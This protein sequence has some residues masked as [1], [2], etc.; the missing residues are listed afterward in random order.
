[1]PGSGVKQSFWPSNLKAYTARRLSPGTYGSRWLDSKTPEF[2]ISLPLL[3][4]RYS[5]DRLSV[6]YQLPEGATVG[7]LSVLCGCTHN[8]GR[9][10]MAALLTEPLSKGQARANS[11][12]SAP[13]DVVNP[14]AGP[15]HEGDRH[16]H[17]RGSP[18]ASD[19]PDGRGCRCSRDHGLWRRLPW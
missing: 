16:R 1:M 8:A 11:A 17:D 14:V 19:R 9:S 7:E 2:W 12:G 18:K 13:S 10:Q 6:Q 4:R 3:M 5:E 15:S